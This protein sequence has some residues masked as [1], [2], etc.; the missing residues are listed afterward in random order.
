MGERVQAILGDKGRQRAEI[1]ATA[2]Q[3]EAE[4]R[5][6]EERIALVRA[7]AERRIRKIIEEREEKAAKAEQLRVE[8]TGIAIK[9]EERRAAWSTALRE[10]GAAL[11]T[12]LVGRVNA[13]RDRETARKSAVVALG[14]AAVV[15]YEEV[16]RRARDGTD[17]LATYIS[18]PGNPRPLRIFRPL[19]TT[20]GNV[21]FSVRSV[22]R[23]RTRIGSG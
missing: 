1:E 20:S 2:E 3:L 23:T 13:L 12:T 18:Q 9:P 8:A 5:L 16:R 4:C 19:P 22:R 15:R 21:V 11:T 17:R 10:R 14:E 6:S 7:D